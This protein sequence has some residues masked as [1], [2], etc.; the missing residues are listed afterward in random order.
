M[1]FQKPE[2]SGFNAA[3][4]VHLSSFKFTLMI[5]FRTRAIYPLSGSVVIQS[6]LISFCLVRGPDAGTLCEKDSIKVSPD[7]SSLK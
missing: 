3:I 6:D 4:F 5:A 2:I 7:L 1:R